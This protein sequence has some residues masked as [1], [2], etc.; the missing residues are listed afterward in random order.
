MNG[1]DVD[2]AGAARRRGVDVAFGLPGA[3]NLALWPACEAAGVR[4]VGMRH[5]Q[6]C[7]YAADGYARA[8]GKVGVALVTTGP[9]AANTV[10]AGR[11]GVGVAL[12]RRRDRDRHPGDLA[13]TRACTAACCTRC[14][15]Q[16]ALFAPVT[17]ARRPTSVDRGAAAL[18]ER[19]RPRRPVY[20]GIP[21]DCCSRRT[22]TCDRSTA[23]AGARPADVD[24]ARR[25]ARPLERDRCCGS[26][27]A[28][29]RGRRRSTRSRAGSARRWS[30]TY[31]AR[32]VLAPDHPLLVPRAAARTRGHRA[33]RT[34]RSRASSS[35]PTST[36]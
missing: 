33:H 26:A 29:A 13:A 9:G 15:D 22:P 20:V 25:R 21:T 36:R 32:G 24:A 4:I 30:T 12:A 27:A 28:R 18:A 10:G 11:R 6:G 34:R 3:H 35:A 23:C 1:A 31:Q 2:R 19:H 5:E 14:T 16:A 7:A 8:T 17:K